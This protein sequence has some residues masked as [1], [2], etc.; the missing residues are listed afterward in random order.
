MLRAV[1]VT[2]VEL[3]VG[4]PLAEDSGAQPVLDV[5]LNATATTSR[6]RPLVRAPGGTVQPLPDGC[7]ARSQTWRRVRPDT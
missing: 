2:A 5:V 6:S 3:L 4:S 7:L 1:G